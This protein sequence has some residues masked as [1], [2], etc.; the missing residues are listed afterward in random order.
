[1]LAWQP[2]GEHAQRAAARALAGLAPIT[3][4]LPVALPDV[5]LG[6]GLAREPLDFELALAAPGDVG[7]DAAALAAVDSIILAGIADGAAPGAALAVGRHGKLVRLAGYGRLDTRAGFGAVTDSTI[8]DLASLTK[9]I[10]TTTAAMLMVEAG[11]L[12]LDRRVAEYLPEWKGS[13]EKMAVTVRHLLRHNAGL[14]AFLPLY[15]DTR[16][17]E[18]Y[19]ARIGETELEYTPGT[20]TIYSDLGLILTGL[21]VERISGHT[22]DRLLAE[23]VF[24]PLGMHDTGYNPM[25]WPAPP[26]DAETWAPFAPVPPASPEPAGEP[27]ALLARIAPTEV[28]TVFRMRHIHGVVHDENAYAIGGV[29]GHAGLFSS[30]RDLARFA[31]MMLDGGFLEGRRILRPGTVARFTARQDSAS[32]RALG[33]DTP[34]RMSSAGDYFSPVSFGHTGFTGTTCSSCC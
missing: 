14:P 1:M 4:K 22:V 12:D 10:G 15:R 34:S 19:L 6:G 7:M 24:G 27:P 26:A 20:R 5:P 16:G 9:V 17:R 21:I 30:A 33:W 8:W 13:P 3:G 18:Q 31:Q 11:R 29:S 2:Y 25:H 28:D 32:S 23:R